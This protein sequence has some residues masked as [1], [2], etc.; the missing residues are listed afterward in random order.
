MRG[1]IEM[2][3]IMSILNFLFTLT[4]AVLSGFG[5]LGIIV[6]KTCLKQKKR[7]TVCASGSENMYISEDVDEMNSEEA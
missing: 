2:D 6:Y 7:L 1:E 5:V 4:A 3:I